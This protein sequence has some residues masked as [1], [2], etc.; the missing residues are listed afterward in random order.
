MIVFEDVTEFLNNKRL[1]LN[2]ELARQ[3]AHEIKNP[4]TPIQLSIQLLNQAYQDGADNLDVIV[5]DTVERVLEQVRLLRSI[6]TEFSLLGRPDELECEPVSMPDLVDKVLSGYQTVSPTA[7][8][9]GP[10]LAVA[11][12]KVPPVLAHPESLIKV[13]SNLME[14]SIDACGGLENLGLQVSWRVTANEVTLLWEDD[15]PG[16]A[17]EV[18]GRLF[19]PYFSTKSMGTGLG[20]AI[21]RNLL[22][23]MDGRISLANRAK[24]SGAVAEVTLPRFFGENEGGPE[25][26]GSPEES[27]GTE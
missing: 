17:P 1:A 7:G 2:A 20:L 25:P 8:S 16:L 27:G 3:V 13:L 18:A 24:V 14:N 23:K 15:G 22:D 9:I 10:R 6:A 5:E 26:S 11:A 19:D 4:L 21:C 12:T